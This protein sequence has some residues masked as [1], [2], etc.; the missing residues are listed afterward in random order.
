MC[1]CSSAAIGRPIWASPSRSAIARRTI[2]R[3]P[4]AFHVY[5]IERARILSR[6]REPHAVLRSLRHTSP[7]C[8]IN[9]SHS[10]LRPS[11]CARNLH[12]LEMTMRNR[13]PRPCIRDLLDGAGFGSE[14]LLRGQQQSL[15][16]TELWLAARKRDKDVDARC[17]TSQ[18]RLPVIRASNFELWPTMP[19]HWPRMTRTE[20]EPS[21]CILVRSR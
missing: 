14:W 11:A 13:P 8:G 9:A 18:L 21:I 6:A 12:G 3:A 19:N 16:P 4:S 1:A 10:R 15:K 5:G 7:G 2:G 17:S 20:L